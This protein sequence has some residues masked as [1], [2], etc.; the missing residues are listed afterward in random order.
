MRRELLQTWPPTPT[1]Y[2]KPG[3]S[4]AAPPPAPPS[5]P[6]T[7]PHS[8]RDCRPP[9]AHR[10]DPPAPRQY[11]VPVV[12]PT[13]YEVTPL[14]AALELSDGTPLSCLLQTAPTVVRYRSV[15][16]VPLDPNNGEAVTAS[17]CRDSVETRWRQW[18][19]SLLVPQFTLHLLGHASIPA[20]SLCIAGS[21]RGAFFQL[22]LPARC[23][24]DA[25]CPLSTS[26][27][28]AE[29]SKPGEGA[30][31]MLAALTLVSLRRPHRSSSRS[32]TLVCPVDAASPKRA[33]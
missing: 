24:V 18:Q 30:D 2:G 1:K 31:V 28:R 32:G 27:R 3:A 33:E 20:P 4:T 5:P 6:S 21:F 8:R 11:P 26:A 23:P 14:A 15:D 17:H 13:V 12:A 29:D 25:V 19:H 9:R 10:L 16:P 22:P 7:R